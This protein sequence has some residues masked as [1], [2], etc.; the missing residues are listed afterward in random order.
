MHIATAIHLLMRFLKALIILNLAL[1]VA[2]QSMALPAYMQTLHSSYKIK[3]E[4]IIG[5]AQCMACHIK[6]PK[7]NSFGLQVQA[8]LAGGDL[9]TELLKGIEKDDADNDGV[10]NGTELAG[11]SLP[12][13]AESKPTGGSQSTGAA[14]VPAKSILPTHAF[15]PLIVH[16]PIALFLFGVVLD[17]WGG[18]RK[19]D[20]LRLGAKWNLTVGAL[21]SL[22]A[23]PTGLLARSFK[24]YDFSGAVLVHL[25]F[26][27]SASILMLFIAG[28]RQKSAP[29]SKAY[30]L[31]LGLSAIAVGVA[32]HFGASLV[33]G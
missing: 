33:F 16:F 19:S 8:T 27:V 10:S 25:L 22:G 7:L 4:S 20:A 15:H 21:A 29:V 1:V 13:D 30:W 28:W 9:K 26:A 11:D 3:P 24:G 14:I 5:K 6:P 31:I 12:G 18:M 23:V 32:G 17:A 2:G